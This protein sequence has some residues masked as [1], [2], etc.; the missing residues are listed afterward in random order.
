MARERS[1]SK[2]T[3]LENRCKHFKKKAAEQSKENRLLR[4]QVKSLKASRDKWKRKAKQARSASNTAYSEFVESGPPH[5]HR[6][7]VWLIT[8]TLKLYVFCRCSLRG[9]VVVLRL[10]FGDKVPCKSTVLNWLRKAGYAV[11]Q[12]KPEIDTGGYA[13]ILDESMVIGQ[14][15]MIYVTI[16]DAIKRGNKAL[17]F[18]CIKATYLSVAPSWKGKEIAVFLQGIIRKLG[19]APRYVISD[20]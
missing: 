20:Y 2:E 1:K 19:K 9:T 10:F 14:Q 17:T 5:G 4:A 18:T 6:Y 11:Y 16:V 15:R 3:I 7:P 12:Q 8:I 13:M